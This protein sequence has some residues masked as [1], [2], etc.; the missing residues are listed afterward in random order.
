MKR[1]SVV[2]LAITLVAVIASYIV[3]DIAMKRVLDRCDTDGGGA[4]A[5]SACTE[6]IRRDPTDYI[7][8][9]NR[10]NA[11]QDLG[12]RDQAIADYT[13]AIDIVPSYVAAY[14][15]RGNAYLRAGL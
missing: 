11:H 10:R 12:D 4:R 2:Y 7:A 5:I 6:L 1:K 14:N 15:N 8:Y 9:Y 3:R 13:K